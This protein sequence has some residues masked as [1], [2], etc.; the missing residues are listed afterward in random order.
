[1]E[2]YLFQVHP[3]QIAQI[4]STTANPTTIPKAY[5]DLEDL[6]SIKNASHFSVHKDHDH[7]I[8]LIDNKQPSYSLIYSL[9]ENELSI[10]QVYIDKNLANRFI[11]S[12]KS[13]AGAPI[14]FVLNLSRD[15]QLYVHH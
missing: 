10:F 9:Y 11:R 8:S 14:F 2:N 13:P 7:A 4:F 12:S 15:L 1:M 6:F 3:S 5:K